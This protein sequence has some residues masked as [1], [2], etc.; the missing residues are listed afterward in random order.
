MANGCPFDLS[1]FTCAHR[2]LPLGSTVLVSTADGRIR[3]RVVVTDRGP[4]VGGRDL[5]VSKAAAEVLGLLEPGV[6]ELRMEV[7][8]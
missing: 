8:K 5:D 6:A 2:T 4:F 3:V 7:L 1:A